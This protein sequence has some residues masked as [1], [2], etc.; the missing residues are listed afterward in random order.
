MKIQMKSGWP[1]KSKI[2]LFPTQND[3]PK[4][5]INYTTCFLG[6]QPPS[7]PRW[8]AKIGSL[9]DVMSNPSGRMCQ[10]NAP[11]GCPELGGEQ[12]STTYPLPS[13]PYL[14]EGRLGWVLSLGA[15]Y[16][17]GGFNMLQV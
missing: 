13:E 8:V 1:M 14:T 4:C 11:D 16:L 17:A 3:D 15:A 5:D 12:A 9:F 7:A 6:Q 10:F 2:F